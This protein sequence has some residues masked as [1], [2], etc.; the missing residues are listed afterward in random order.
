M[1][2]RVLGNLVILKTGLVTYQVTSEAIG[3][4]IIRIVWLACTPLL[5]HGL[6]DFSDKF[7]INIENIFDLSLFE[8]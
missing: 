6:R 8:L 4:V 7:Q 2:D 5:R 1:E 3:H